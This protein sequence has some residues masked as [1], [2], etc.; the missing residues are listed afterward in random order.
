M[1]LSLTPLNEAWNTPAAK[2]KVYNKFGDKKSQSEILK[3]PEIAVP[4]GVDSYVSQPAPLGNSTPEPN[5]VQ[6]IQ[7]TQVVQ[8][9]NTAV[10]Q[11]QPQPE[12]ITI[13]LT[14]PAVLSILKPYNKRFIESIVTGLIVRGYVP[15]GIMMN[16]AG[17][18][19]GRDSI[20][21]FAIMFLIIAIDIVIRSRS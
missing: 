20:Q 11:S 17:T 10:A 8:Q 2:H 4:S 21:M 6:A 19:N 5:Q 16:Q 7:P 14:D 9:T 1:N 18:S 3:E 12:P 13:T 15:N